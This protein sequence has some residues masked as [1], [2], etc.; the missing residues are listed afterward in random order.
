MRAVEATKFQFSIDLYQFSGSNM[1]YIDLA[2][3]K[4]LPQF[5]GGS[6]RYYPRFNASGDG[7]RVYADIQHEL[8][9]ETVWES[10]M[11]VRV[12]FE[13]CIRNYIGSFHRRSRDLLSLPVCHADTNVAFDIL[14]RNPSV[15]VKKDVAY[16]QAA[17]LYTSSSGERMIRIHN[18]P[19]AIANN[20]NEL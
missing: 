17:L 16:V 14:L 5:N 3:L 20:K 4:E 2:T 6:L 18:L 13:Y 1:E 8:T 12:S 19:I 7:L 10:V 11:R 15:A 9:R